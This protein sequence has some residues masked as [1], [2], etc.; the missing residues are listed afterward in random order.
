MTPPMERIQILETIEKDIIVCLQSAGQAFVELS[1][2]KSSVKQA[3]AQTQQFI[4]TLGHVESKLSEQI[5]YLTQVSTGQP[6]EGSGYASQKVLQM[7]WHR[8]EHARSRVNEL[9]RIKNKPR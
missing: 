8:L 2:E 5:N 9:E 6:H 1:K 7:A 4:K 3:E